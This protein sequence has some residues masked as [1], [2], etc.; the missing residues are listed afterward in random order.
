MTRRP[1][2][3]WRLILFPL[4]I[5]IFLICAGPALAGSIYVFDGSAGGG[6]NFF[7]GGLVGERGFTLD[8][9]LQFHPSGQTDA[10]YACGQPQ[11]FEAP[12]EGRCHPGQSI[13]LNVSSS[14]NIL[15]S[16]PSQPDIPGHAT[17]DGKSYV[18]GGLLSDGS[19]FTPGSAC[20]PP[21]SSFC[22]PPTSGLAY[23]FLA[24][25]VMAPPFCDQPGSVGCS[26]TL[27]APFQFTGTFGHL[28]D[29]TG[30]IVMDELVGSGI[31][32]LE[33]FQRTVNGDSFWQMDFGAQSY[34]IQPTPE[35]ATL[36]LVG[37]GA[38]GV[39]LARWLK[40]RRA[41]GH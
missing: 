36:L 16:G 27:T 33:L 5:L 1:G 14:L 23:T 15:A 13:S 25:A 37:T 3:C 31:A 8:G 34:D 17:L 18:V 39:G 12:R 10:F 26:A 29:S 22:A 19:G 30:Q 28:D 4:A 41:R 2:Y 24:P 6:R 32:S 35:P 21:Q 40:R 11:P 7:V 9:F 38:A 20:S